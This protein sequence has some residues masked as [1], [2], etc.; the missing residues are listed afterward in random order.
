MCQSSSSS[1]AAIRKSRIK[2]LYLCLLFPWAPPGL[3]CFLP[4]GSLVC[5]LNMF[6]LTGETYFSGMNTKVGAS[7]SCNLTPALLVTLYRV[8]DKSLK[9]KW[10]LCLKILYLVHLQNTSSFT[11]SSKLEENLFLC[12][13]YTTTFIFSALLERVFSTLPWRRPNQKNVKIP[14]EERL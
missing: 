10:H 7:I 3:P 1:C 14:L 2:F 12:T 11:V 6:V 8:T 4:L 9:G 5:F 13:F